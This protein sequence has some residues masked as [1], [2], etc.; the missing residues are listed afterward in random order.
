MRQAWRWLYPGL[1]LKRWIFTFSIGVFMVII[2]LTTIVNYQVFGALEEFLFRLLY[3]VTGRYNYTLLAS[4]GGLFVVLGGVVMVFSFRKL[5]SRILDS[6]APEESGQ[7]SQKIIDRVRRDRG[8][9]VVAIGGGT[10]LSTLLR[11]LKNKT[12]HLSAIVTVADDGG[13]SGR[14][15]EEMNIIAP[16]DLRNCLV[17][18]A[19]KESLMEDVFQHR[20]GGHGEL[21][22]HSLGNLFLA[23]LIEEYGDTEKALEAASEILNVRGEVIPATTEKV[24]LRA[25]MEDGTVVDGES[26][27][28]DAHGRIHRLRMVP[29]APAAVPAS[30]TAIEEADLIT[31]GPGSLYTSILPNLLVPEIAA[32]VRRSPAVK[33]YVCNA[34]TQPGETDGY[35]VSDHVR[36][37]IEHIGPG[38]VDCVL[39]NDRRPAEEVLERYAAIGS[40]PVEVD[41]EELNRLGVKP[42]RANLISEGQTVAHDPTLVADLLVDVVYALQADL[43]PQLLDYYFDRTRG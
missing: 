8:P 9:R 14:L 39:V 21:A 32:A 3:E 43:H 6:I 19:D 27:I 40:Y 31:L 25:E 28:P 16:G 4:L 36:A 2:G 37:L 23:A 10:G 30:V 41:I 22:G 15:R 18:M 35:K 11:G 24:E 33:V 38:V 42:V 7:L 26:Q 5:M 1:Q 34:M 20:F 29:E 17:A 13:S 12:S